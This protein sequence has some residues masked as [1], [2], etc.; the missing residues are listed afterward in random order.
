MHT[1]TFGEEL[2]RLRREARRSLVDLADAAGCSIAFVSDVERGRKHPP[3]PVVIRKMLR[4]IGKEDHLER[5]L[6]LAA[7]ARR[8]VEISVEGKDEVVTSMLLALARRCDEGS[9]TDEVAQQIQHLLER[10]EKP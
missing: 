5:L 8:R 7:Q 4:A 2:R 10:G 3:A 6:I 1:K 9:L